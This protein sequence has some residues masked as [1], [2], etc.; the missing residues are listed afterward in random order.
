MATVDTQFGPLDTGRR[1][2]LDELRDADFE[3]GYRSELGRGVLEVTK[4]PGT[5]HCRIADLLARRFTLLIRD[6]VSWREQVIPDARAI[7]S[8]V[9]PGLMTTV[10]DLDY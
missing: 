4:V 5:R 8:V 10:A 2:T 9:L 1:P 3:E 7:P 6:G